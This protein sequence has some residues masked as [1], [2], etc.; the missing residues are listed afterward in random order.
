MAARL[1]SRSAFSTKPTLEGGTAGLVG[2]SV[3]PCTMKQLAW[4]GDWVG[5]PAEELHTRVCC[6]HVGWYGPGV[7]GIRVP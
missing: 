3:T 4:P 7:R 6:M 2:G 1:L 5:K